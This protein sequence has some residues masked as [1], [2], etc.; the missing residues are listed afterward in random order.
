M[1]A[2]DVC[3]TR[4]HSVS[5]KMQ[6]KSCKSHVLFFFSPRHPMLKISHRIFNI[7]TDMPARTH[8]WSS[9]H[10]YSR[11]ITANLRLKYVWDWHPYPPLPFK[12]FKGFPSS[13]A[14]TNSISSRQRD[15]V[16]VH[17]TCLRS[18][19]PTIRPRVV[20]VLRLGKHAVA[21]RTKADLAHKT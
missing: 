2:V 12:H 17:G 15:R 8:T 13:A 7:F 18:K 20:V 9:S 5:C 4:G 3:N 14:C 11:Y 1:I 16:M 21:W 10:F 19:R 6:R